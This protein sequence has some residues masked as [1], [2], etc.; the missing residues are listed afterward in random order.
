MK[1]TEEELNRNVI[2][3]SAIEGV[4]PNLI[5]TVLAMRA[6]RFPSKTKKKVRK[7]YGRTKKV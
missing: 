2:S 4:K 3:S 5:T 7:K 6:K 1:F